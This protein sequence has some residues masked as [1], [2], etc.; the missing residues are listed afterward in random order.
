MNPSSKMAIVVVIAVVVAASG[1]FLFHFG[2]PEVESWGGIEGTVTWIDEPV[3]G[4][5][6]GI[7]SGSTGFPEIAVETNDD[8]YYHI[9][10]VPPGTFEV[11][12]HDREGNRL[13][14]ES[15]AVRGGEISTLN[16]VIPWDNAAS[17]IACPKDGSLYIWTPIGTRSE[18]FNWRCLRCGHTWVKTYPEDVYE[19]WR[20]AFL[21]PHYVRD[22]TVLYLREIAHEYLP[23]PLKLEWSGGRETPA[24]LVGSETYIYRAEGV[25]VTIKYPVVLPEN[26]IYEI[27][28][29][30]QGVR[31]WEGRLHQRQFIPDVSTPLDRTVYDYYGGVGLFEEGIYV[32]ATDKD[33]TADF[34]QTTTDYW[35]QLK[36]KTTRQA[37]TQDFISIV[38]S[39]GDFPTGGY[40]IQL[41]S[42]VWLESYP[43]VFSLD[44]NFTDPGE[45]VAV[46]EAFTNPLVLIPIGNLS[47][48]KYVVEVHIDR[49]ILTYDKSGEA[50]YTPIKTLVE[51]VWKENFDILS[52]MEEKGFLEGRVWFI[53]VP[54]PP[55][56]INGCK[57]QV[58]P[59]DGPYPNYEITV[60][61]TDGKTIVAK[62]I[63][64]EDGYYQISLDP[65]NYYIY[66]QNG[67]LK[68]HIK[69][70][71]V[72]IESCI[73]TKLDLIVDTGIR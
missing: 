3:S 57:P 60:Y 6:V 29:E 21:E 47:E 46:T 45:G 15:V 50:V 42:F 59:C 33:A 67:P 14:I 12:V 8:G 66:T 54:C 24:S 5:M 26:T 62:T 28:V 37:S 55:E 49:F 58:P 43:V 11:A 18:N 63:S 17:E 35:K 40:Q 65:G 56:E 7:V 31:V 71:Q 19:R 2:Y 68:D 41:K 69:T 44:A 51:E 52:P 30:N 38:I 1:F 53:G 25:V 32:I 4:M 9:G 36:E 73:T 39:R 22:Y 61:K 72:T 48:G 10:S 20:Q 23:D 64:D 16:L 13:C 34:R 70:N 27:R